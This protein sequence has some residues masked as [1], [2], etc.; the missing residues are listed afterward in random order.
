MVLG[1]ILWKENCLMDFKNDIN[2][3]DRESNIKFDLYKVKVPTSNDIYFRSK[4]QEL[5][6]Q[7]RGARIF[8]YETETDDWNHWFNT[9]DKEAEKAFRLIYRSYFYEAALFYYNTLVDLSWVLCYVSIEYACGKNGSRVDFSGMKP[10]E[11]TYELLRDAEKNVTSPTADENPFEYLK[12]MCP[13]FATVID[14][15]IDFWKRFSSTNIRNRYNYCKHRGRLAYSEIEKLRGGR[16]ANIYAVDQ[17]SG[18]NIHIA[19]DIRDVK[20][21]VSLEDGIL[22]LQEFDDNILFPYLKDL[23]ESIEKI[24]DPSPII[25]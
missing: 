24:L 16:V 11:E 25:F 13:E 23:L 2:T 21:E 5:V 14:Q 6:D 17:S 19:T 15:I 1:K 18:E 7:Y 8:M 20:N 3:L 4:Q 12:K 10:I 9:E 22:E